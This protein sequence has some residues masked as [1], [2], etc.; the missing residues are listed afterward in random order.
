MTEPV[1][2]AAR[3]P[4][5][6]R[7]ATAFV[8]RTLL[9]LFAALALAATPLSVGESL[10]QGKPAAIAPLGFDDRTA[11]AQA[12]RDRSFFELAKLASSPPAGGETGDDVLVAPSHLFP[13]SRDGSEGPQPVLRPIRL[14]HRP[15]GFTSRAP[16]RLISHA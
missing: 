14:A 5:R 15:L 1:A 3:R 4:E 8:A 2:I 7:P 10:A 6:T 13:R 11:S 16:P 9:W 12:E